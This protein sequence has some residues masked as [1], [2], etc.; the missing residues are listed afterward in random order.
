MTD[1]D[2]KPVNPCIECGIETKPCPLLPAGCFFA[3]RY[4]GEIEG[5]KRLLRYQIT[6][7]QHPPYA[8]NPTE[9]TISVYRLKLMLKELEEL[10]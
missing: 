7:T 10:K 4:E 1:T 2:W 9:K 3:D 6:S 5:Q 8:D